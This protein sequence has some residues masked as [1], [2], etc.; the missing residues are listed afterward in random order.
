MLGK[1]RGALYQHTDLDI[2]L[3]FQVYV[4][5]RGEDCASTASVTLFVV[6]RQCDAIAIRLSIF[7]PPR[8]REIFGAM[9]FGGQRPSRAFNR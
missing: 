4:A 3:G 5:D 8:R 2:I 7:T 9:F 1:R 6:I